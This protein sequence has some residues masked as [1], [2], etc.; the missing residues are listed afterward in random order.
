[1]SI[2]II[3]LIV[4][5]FTKT[6][7]KPSEV[8]LSYRIL[9]SFLFSVSVIAILLLS[10]FYKNKQYD[11][12]SVVVFVTMMSFMAWGGG[13]SILDSIS[14]SCTDL[15]YFTIALI[16]TAVF[17]CVEPWVTAI[18]IGVVSISTV[19]LFVVLVNKNI[20]ADTKLSG[21]FW[22]AVPTIVLLAIGG[23]WLNFGRRVAA[24]R[25]ELKVSSLNRE[26]EAKA[27][28]DELTKVYN[29]RYLTENIDA[30]LC[31]GD[32]CSSVM[33]IDLDH[34]KN[35]NDTYGHQVGD[36][37]L[38]MIGDEILNLIKDLDAY[39]VRYGGEEFLIFFKQITKQTLIELAEK[40]RKTIEEHIIHVQGGN[41]LSLTVS[42]GLA[43]AES[44]I[45]YNKLINRA[46][47]AL[48][49]AKETRNTVT[50]FE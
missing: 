32:I 42:I 3:M 11:A 9:Y 37:C 23:S 13:I 25:L 46:D 24:I 34:F 14:H 29:R 47:T 26:L 48:Y 36:K 35:I 6:G 39:C 28:V 38:A 44:N 45:S 27:Y 19:M 17:V 4:S 49:E 30:P 43:G 20:I 5:F 15:L 10:R 50:Y 33:M 18:S 12:Y 31:Y 2:Q 41:I 16:A 1:M 8:V 22:L 7:S 21:G 40:Y